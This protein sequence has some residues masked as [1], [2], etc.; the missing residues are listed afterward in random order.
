MCSTKR[1]LITMSFIIL[2][3]IFTVVPRVESLS[4]STET[5]NTITLDPIA[6]RSVSPASQYNESI[7]I[8]MS[9]EYGIKQFVYVA[10]DLS[11]LP[12]NAII[13]STVFKIKNEAISYAC[14]VSAF[15]SVNADW[16]E[17]GIM[18][19][20][21]PDFGEY[22]NAVYVRTMREWYSW[23]SDSLNKAVFESLQE[24]KRIT[25]ALKTGTKDASQYGLVIFYTDARLEI[26]YTLQIPTS[27]TCNLSPTMVSSGDKITI[28]GQISP[29][30]EG[31]DI[32][33]SIT[34]PDGS[35]NTI[36][37]K[38]KSGGSYN[39]T[40]TPDKVGTWKVIVSW[41]GDANH[42]GN[43]SSAVSFTVMKA[44]TTISIKFSSSKITKG[45]DIVI[46]GAIIPAVSGKT[47]VI[48]YTKPD[49]S[50]FTRSTTT[51]PNGSYANS[52]KPTETGSWS[53]KVSWE[54][55]ALNQE[56]SSSSTS[57]TVEEEK[58][59]CIVATATYGSELSSEVQFLR[60][61]RDNTVLNTFAGSNFMNVFNA[62]YYSFSPKLASEIALND[63]LR[64][65]MKIILYPLIGILHLSAISYSLL[66]FNSEIGVMVAGLIASSLIGLEYFTPCV[67]IPC[68][69]KKIK[70]PTKI[71][72]VLLLILVVSVGCIIVTEMTQWQIVMTFS[73]TI[74]VLTTMFLSTLT[75]TKLLIKSVTRAP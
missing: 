69:I 14:S 10:F 25:I 21:K 72:H 52:Y 56:A 46:T 75:F 4:S 26:N 27:L 54:G 17:K 8:V 19:D 49:G 63:V 58:K 18:W 38:T 42:E 22:I 33:I 39:A 55:D 44:S 67:L 9:I 71:L 43:S 35:L 32:K 23:E 66:S 68:L 62:W 41:E 15:C 36:T 34:S 24:T 30:V 13:T 6:A 31:A 64:G 12:K 28:D 2:C 60:G 70:I 50:T 20:T 1:I 53:V 3:F 45:G 65:F 61:F 51:G 11:K 59:G 48:T 16:V 47:V 7:L 5:M 73:T 29:L 40:F 74:F 37:V 57:F